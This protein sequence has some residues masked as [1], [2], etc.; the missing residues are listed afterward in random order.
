MIYINDFNAALIR[1]CPPMNIIVQ[2]VVNIKIVLNFGIHFLTVPKYI[3]ITRNCVY[4]TLCPQPL[5][6]R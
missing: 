2:S 4:E 5:A 6:C 3:Y 1:T